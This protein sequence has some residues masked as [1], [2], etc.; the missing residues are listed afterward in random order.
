MEALKQRVTTIEKEV[1]EIKITLKE[2]DDKIDS[3]EKTM[4]EKIEKNQQDIKHI[5]KENELMQKE[6]SDKLYDKIDKLT[7]SQYQQTLSQKDMQNELKTT[8]RDFTNL[9]N[10]MKDNDKWKTRTIA[11]FVISLV[12]MI[13]G[14][15]WKMAVSTVSILPFLL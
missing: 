5:L 12:L 6:K 14:T 11:G 7:E 13:I 2:L 15:F 9:A 4:M 3:N 10:D 8:I 1:K